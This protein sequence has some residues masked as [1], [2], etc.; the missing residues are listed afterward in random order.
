MAIGA[1]LRLQVIAL[2][3]P[4]FDT[5]MTLRRPGL[6]EAVVDPR[7]ERAQGD[8]AEVG[9][10]G[11]R[12][13]RPAESPR[14]LDLDPLGAAVHRLLERPLHRPAETRPLL[15]LL[16]DV[17]ADQLRV[18]LGPVDLDDLDLDPATGQ[19]LELL[20]ELVDLGPLA[21]DDDPGPGG[22]EEHRDG[23]PRPFDLDL[24]DARVAVL[25]LDELADLE[26]LDQQVLEFML[27]GVPATA[28]VLHDTDA[29]PGRMY[30]LAHGSTSPRHRAG[31]VWSV[32]TGWSSIDPPHPAEDGTQS[33]LSPPPRSDSRSVRPIW[34]C[35]LRRRIMYA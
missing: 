35:E 25:P 22:R 1:A 4:H 32:R 26:I 23:V 5:D 28:P 20:L 19:P 2:V 34:M 27:G 18:D 33:F 7:P 31:C 17:L 8:R 10:L 13:L 24:G 12:H 30:L 16:G 11:P 14:E 29:E 21:A 6:G 3:D 15:E 9:P